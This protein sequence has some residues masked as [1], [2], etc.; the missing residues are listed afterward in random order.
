M[1]FFVP[2]TNNQKAFTLCLPEIDDPW[3]QLNKFSSDSN[4]T[5]KMFNLGQNYVCKNAFRLAYLMRIESIQL[6]KA[7]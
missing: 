6:C 3:T 5:N 1:L 4:E 7:W 2:S